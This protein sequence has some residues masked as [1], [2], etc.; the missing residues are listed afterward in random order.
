M[1]ESGDGMERKN[2]KREESEESEQLS[3][4]HRPCPVTA[5]ETDSG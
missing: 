3:R 5:A 2:E 4:Q 1:K